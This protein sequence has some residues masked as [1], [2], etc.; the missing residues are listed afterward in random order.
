MILNISGTNLRWNRVVFKMTKTCLFVLGMHRSG[1][2]AMAGSIAK[3][4]VGVDTNLVEAVANDNPKGYWEPVDVVEIN[5]DILAIFDMH[6]MDYKSFPEGWEQDSK[7]DDIRKRIEVWCRS[8]FSEHALIAVK[9]PRI[10][11]TLPLW[12]QVLK[13]ID[14]EAKY[15]HMVRHPMDVISSLQV[16]DEK[17][18]ASEGLLVWAVHVLDAFSFA[19][20]DQSVVVSY[21]SLMR[22]PVHVLEQVGKVLNIKWPICLAVQGGGIKD[23]IDPDLAHHSYKGEVPYAPLGPLLAKTFDVLTSIEMEVLSKVSCEMLGE[24]LQDVAEYRAFIESV[25]ENIRGLLRL[26]QENAKAQV[27]YRDVLVSDL[28]GLL[29]SEKKNAR[30]QITYRDALIADLEAKLKPGQ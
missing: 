26:E 12:N 20:Y 2:S 18:S 14:C 23:F 25:C 28:K 13:K 10:C 9:D 6:Y 21:G 29:E 27:E 24:K 7:L 22:S 17:F 1:T 15:I 3:L 4:G 8:M 19:K 5:N 30:E 16:R 11:R